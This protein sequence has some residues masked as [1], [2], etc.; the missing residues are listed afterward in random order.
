MPTSRGHLTSLSSREMITVD[1]RHGPRT[2]STHVSN[3]VKKAI[4][5]FQ[6]SIVVVRRDGGSVQYGSP[7][8]VRRNVSDFNFF[9]VDVSAC[10]NSLSFRFRRTTPRG[11]HV[12]RVKDYRIRASVK[13]YSKILIPTAAMLRVGYG[14]LAAMLRAV[15]DGFWR[16]A[17]TLRADPGAMLRVH[18][19][20]SRVVKPEIL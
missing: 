19:R 5:F 8:S 7:G 15:I 4:W 12:V 14:M 1:D 13:S 6:I 17:A 16:S 3:T 9:D 11:D 2:S 20:L 10:N 18:A